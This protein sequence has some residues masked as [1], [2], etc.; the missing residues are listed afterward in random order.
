MNKRVKAIHK[1]IA[2]SPRV[3]SYSISIRSALEEIDVSIVSS[4]REETSFTTIEKAQT[5]Q[6]RIVNICLGDATLPVKVLRIR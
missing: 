1:V 2:A 6:I 5:I 3:V 4:T